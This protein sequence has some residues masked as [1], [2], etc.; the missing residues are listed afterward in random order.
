MKFKVNVYNC[1][2]KGALDFV[3]IFEKSTEGSSTDLGVSY[4]ILNCN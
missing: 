3:W 2:L 1:Y 4:S